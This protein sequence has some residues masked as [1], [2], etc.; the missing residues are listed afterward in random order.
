MSPRASVRVCLS[1][2]LVIVTGVG[3]TPLLSAPSVAQAA[4]VLPALPNVY[5][6]TAYAPISVALVQELREHIDAARATAA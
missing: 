5:L 1:W 2:L 6:N 3:A 4:P